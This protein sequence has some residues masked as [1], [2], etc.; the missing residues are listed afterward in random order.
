MASARKSPATNPPVASAACQTADGSAFAYE[1]DDAAEP[2][3][4]EED[5]EPATHV[6][7]DV[8]AEGEGAE[9]QGHEPH[10][11]PEHRPRLI[12]LSAVDGAGLSP[13]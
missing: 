11:L 12:P 1:P 10:D 13:R 7:P 5:S 9:R 8:C 2:C 3:N 6:P 4:E